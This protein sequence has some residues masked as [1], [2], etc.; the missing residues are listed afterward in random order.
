MGQQQHHP[1]GSD[2]AHDTVR[3]PT[4]DARMDADQ[5]IRDQKELKERQTGH[6]KSGRLPGKQQGV[7]VDQHDAG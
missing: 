7:P 4:G 6:Q 2:K 5:R 3:T 1:Q